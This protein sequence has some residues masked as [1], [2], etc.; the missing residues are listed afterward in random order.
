M[1][2]IQKEYAEF[3]RETD[4][5]LAL[6]RSVSGL[7]PSH[8]KVIAEIALLR[9]SILLENKLK[10]IVCKLCCGAKYLD[11]S[12]P[13]LSFQQRSMKAAILSMQTFNRAK[14]RHPIWNDGKEIREN[15]CH[16]IK[17]TDHCI[18]TMIL[19]APFLSEV[20]Y[21]RN[22]I[23]HHNETS[24]RNYKNVV[25]KHYGAFCHAV[26]CGTLLL[27]ERASRPPLLEKYLITSRVLM[28]DFT[29]S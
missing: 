2:S 13:L 26:T 25:K 4:R 19:Y 17:G 20:R 7:T 28:K 11:G 14:F 3:R 24:R 22:H 29:K 8:R 9:L 27:S 5:L 15:V 12:D 21:I 23:A 16:L 10:L 18:S 1:P 6:L